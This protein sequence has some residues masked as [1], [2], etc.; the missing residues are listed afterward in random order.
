MDPS[1]IDGIASLKIMTSVIIL[2]D[3]CDAGHQVEVIKREFR[4]TFAVPPDEKITGEKRPV[5][6]LCFLIAPFAVFLQ[7][8]PYLKIPGSVQTEEFCDSVTDVF[9][10]PRNAVQAKIHGKKDI[11]II[12]CR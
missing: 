7:G 4:F 8:K 5:S 2:E 1:C 6:C 10:L 11:T 3:S 9:F 12:Y